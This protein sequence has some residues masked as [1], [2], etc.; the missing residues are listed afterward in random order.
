VTV[1][2]KTG[3]GAVIDTKTV[4]LSPGGSQPVS[5]T[6]PFTTLGPKRT[7]IRAGGSSASAITNVTTVNLA[8]IGLH[9]FDDVRT[10]P[11]TND[12][13]SGEIVFDR[14]EET[15]PTSGQVLVGIENGPKKLVSFDVDSLGQPTEEFKLNVSRKY[16]GNQTLIAK[17]GFN[18]TRTVGANEEWASNNVTEEVYLYGHPLTDDRDKTNVTIT[19][20]DDR[21][22]ENDMIKADVK[23]EATEFENDLIRGMLDVS[24][25]NTSVA[26]EVPYTIRGS[27]GGETKRTVAL[28]VSEAVAGR[29]TLNAST[30]GDYDTRPIHPYGHLVRNA[31]KTSVSISSITDR[32]EEDDTV[33]VGVRID[34]DPQFTGK[35]SGYLNV[36]IEGTDVSKEV[37]YTTPEREYAGVNKDVTLNVS[38]AIA[39]RQ[40][41]NASTKGG[42]DDALVHLYGQLQKGVENTTVA[43]SS[44]E[45]PPNASGVIRA[46]VRIDKNPDFIGRAGGFLT[47]NV[48]NTSLSKQTGYTMGT[49]P[50]ASATKTVTFDV[51]REH[52]GNQTINASIA[53]GY[54]TANTTVALGKG[55]TDIVINDVANVNDNQVD[56]NVT[57]RN[58]G[59]F[60]V[61]T[62]VRSILAG[63]SNDDSKALRTVTLAPG[64]ATTFTQRVGETWADTKGQH[65][66]V[67]STRHDTATEQFEFI[68]DSSAL[69]MDV[70]N[71]RL[72]DGGDTVASTIH[73]DSGSTDP[74]FT[75]VFVK[76][77]KDGAF[78]QDR[79]PTLGANDETTLTLKAPADAFGDGVQPIIY[80]MHQKPGQY[81]IVYFDFGTGNVVDKPDDAVKIDNISAPSSTQVGQA[82]DITAVVNNTADSEVI[83]DVRFTTGLGGTI[84]AKPVKL[85]AGEVDTV[86]VTRE[87]SIAVEMVTVAE[88]G[89]SREVAVTD[90]EEIEGVTPTFGMEGSGANT[91]LIVDTVVQRNYT[92]TDMNIWS[93]GSSTNYTSVTPSLSTNYTASE[94][95]FDVDITPPGGKI[96]V[97]NTNVTLKGEQTP[98]VTEDATIRMNG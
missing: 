14:Q 94:R 1:S 2:F 9:D 68:N 18:G 78:I 70:S 69:T 90:V 66:V 59:D 60:T 75:D 20:V 34:K 65:T 40:T 45:S 10:P 19:G 47:V 87:P 44:V 4:E 39:G 17:S 53:S 50:F 15:E 26:T 56:V 24:I 35:A 95:E 21:S 88:V 89:Q 41:I 61:T 96:T 12:T 46:T 63:Y 93:N 92:V 5:T 86:T 27:V 49:G 72:I 38:E 8:E 13:V 67:S 54:D 57:V 23:I 22:E 7:V 85:A 37:P 6:R 79:Q 80:T 58:T 48:E 43:I 30:E 98:A 71:T 32:S 82:T 16:A 62:P 81:E 77:K 74:G 52:I 91:T 51:G 28:N 97:I 29:Q 83:T 11:I 73:L 25:D 3:I 36:T 33:G 76:S 55:D 42:S 31:E 84:T 64:E